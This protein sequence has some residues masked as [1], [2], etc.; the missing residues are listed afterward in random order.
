[1]HIWGCHITAC[2]TFWHHWRYFCK[3]VKSTF[4]VW[5]VPGASPCSFYELCDAMIGRNRLNRLLQ[6]NRLSLRNNRVKFTTAGNL[7]ILLEEFI[8]IYPNLIKANR[9]LSTCN[10]LDLQTLGS[11]PIMYA[12]TSPRSLALVALN[13]EN[14]PRFM[15]R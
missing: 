2:N 15:Y 10:R 4:A 3:R 1:V 9:R 12:Q 14:W 13:G 5:E 6:M 7:P 8:G 11:Q